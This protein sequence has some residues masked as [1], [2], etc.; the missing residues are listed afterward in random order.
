MILTFLPLFPLLS[1][2]SISSLPSR[3]TSTASAEF[4]SNPTAND[5][6]L[7]ISPP[8]LLILNSSLQKYLSLDLCYLQETSKISTQGLWSTPPT[9]GEINWSSED[10]MCT[11]YNY[12]NSTNDIPQ[13]LDTSHGLQARDSGKFLRWVLGDF[14]R[15][16]R[17]SSLKQWMRNKT[18]LLR[19]ILREYSVPV[20]LPLALVLAIFDFLDNRRSRTANLR[21]RTEPQ[22]HAVDAFTPRSEAQT[23]AVDAYS[24]PCSEAQTQ[25]DNTYS[26]PLTEPQ[27]G[28]PPGETKKP[29]GRPKGS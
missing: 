9:C 4:V 22:I 16:P 20:G 3:T 12:T 5:I 29:R 2:L 25:T 23:Q 6:T 1:L 17:I 10:E 27:P 26:S 24:A 7:P 8:C 28:T 18:H 14:L 21:A 19:P 11:S 13:F 15:D